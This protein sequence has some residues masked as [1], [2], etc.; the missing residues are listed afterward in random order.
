V[1]VNNLFSKDVAWTA[2]V[3]GVATI[4]GILTS[5]LLARILGP[6][7]RGELAAIQNLPSILLGFGALGMTTAAGYFSGRDPNLSGRLM[8]TSLAASIVSSIPLLTIVYLSIPTLLNAQ[9]SSVIQYAQIY[10]L[11]IPIQFAISAPFWVLQCTGRFKIWNFLR[12]QAPIAWLAVIVFTWAQDLAMVS[13]ILLLHLIAMFCI[14]CAF[15]GYAIKKIPGPH[16][17]E[18]SM[19]PRLFRYGW[20]ISLTA[21]P[22]Q[23]NQKLGQLLMAGFMPAETLGIYVVAVAWSNVFSPVLT[24]VSQ[25]LFQRLATNHDKQVQAALLTR[26]MRLTLLT[27]ILL[28]LA[29]VAITPFTLPKVFGMPFVLA[30]PATLVLI[31]ASCIS[32]L[33][34]VASEG[35][36]GLGAP[37]LPMICEFAGL[38]TTI[39][40]LILL[41]R[42]YDLMGAAVASLASYS[43]TLAL[44]MYFIAQRTQLSP[45][46]MVIPSHDDFL[47]VRSEVMKLVRYFIRN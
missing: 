28:S 15:V 45:W 5:V 27:T 10:L 3:N 26:T 46:T 6:E 22:Q 23:L 47:I 4:L 36:R 21:L 32:T 30:I 29:L 18:F 42:P 25:I 34:Q 37:K 39:A 1:S 11:I 9:S 13:S 17:P 19:V 41:L 35:L 7:G 8:T 24:S 31:I 14:A 43:V 33:S 38:T 40:M 12:I 44:S 20:P 2:I 16:R